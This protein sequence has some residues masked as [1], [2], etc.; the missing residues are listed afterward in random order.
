LPHLQQH[1]RLL[2]DWLRVKRADYLGGRRR[3]R[4]GRRLLLPLLHFFLLCRAGVVG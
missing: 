1:Q 2:V 4:R 3:R